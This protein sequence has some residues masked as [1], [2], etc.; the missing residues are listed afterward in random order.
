M[1]L[2]L[3]DASQCFQT[4]TYNASSDFSADSLLFIFEFCVQRQGRG[5]KSE[6]TSC[7]LTSTRDTLF[8]ILSGKL[9]EKRYRLSLVRIWWGEIVL[10][11]LGECLF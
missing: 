10:F 1:L 4:R 2:E 8:L 7:V 5:S 11:F 9:I 3:L 6:R